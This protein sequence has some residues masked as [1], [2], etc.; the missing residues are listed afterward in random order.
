MN[1]L[2]FDTSAQAAGVCVLNESR[3]LSEFTVNNRLTHSQTIMP[4]CQSA[5]SCAHL[6]LQEIDAFAV[7]VGPG[8][9]TGL[10]IGVSAVKGLA[11]AL[12]KPCIPVSTLEGLAYNLTPVSGIICCVMDAR[13]GQ[14]Y[15]ALFRSNGSQTPQRLT[16][17]RA[18]SIKELGVD[19]GKF[20]E[21]IFLV[22]DGADLCYNELRESNP[23]I[24]AVSPHLKLQRASSVGLAAQAAANEG[25]CCSAAE[26]MPVYLRLPQAERELLKKQTIKKESET[27]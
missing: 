16:E 1:I 6:T 23:Q 19:L 9:F 26:L 4:M 21:N 20:D 5:L 7:S 24:R 27:K 11:E 18:V 22:G 17:D 10:R 8:S 25:K 12:K 13:C 14:V 2:A 15:N 3:I